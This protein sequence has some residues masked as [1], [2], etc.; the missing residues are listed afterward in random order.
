MIASTQLHIDGQG[1][2]PALSNSNPYQVPYPGQYFLGFLTFRPSTT[3]A[4]MGLGLLLL[5]TPFP[6]P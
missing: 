2:R 4:M 5:Q 6:F 1:A 3:T